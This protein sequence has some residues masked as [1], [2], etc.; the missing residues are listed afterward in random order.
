MK[1]KFKRETEALRETQSEM[2]LEM[3]NSRSLIKIWVETSEDSLTTR[4]DH[5]TNREMGPED[6]VKS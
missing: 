3:K 5:M 4:I 1:I 6:T 2:Q